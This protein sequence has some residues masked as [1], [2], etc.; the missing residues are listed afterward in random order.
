MSYY[1]PFYGEQVGGGGRGVRNVFIGTRGQRGHGIGSFLGGLFRRALPLISK[2]AR[3]IGK[4]AVRAGMHI[5]DDVSENNMSF[6][7][8]LRNRMAESGINLKRKATEKI[9]DLMEGRGYKGVVAKRRSQSYRSSRGRKKVQRKKTSKVK[10]I[11]R[12]RL[13]GKNR[14]VAAAKKKKNTKS[15]K[16][17]SQK[18]NKVSDIFD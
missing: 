15:K 13:T 12:K 3:A 11:K 16:R 10:K 7:D 8:S 4:E 2:G 17:K 18:R 5:L 1:D 6:K 14:K 9:H